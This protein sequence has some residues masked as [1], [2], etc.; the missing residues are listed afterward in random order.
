[1]SS[2]GKDEVTIRNYL[3]GQLSDEDREE[4]E[5]RYF[6]DEELFDELQAAED[7][8]IDDFLSGNLSQ[9]EVDMFQQN[10]LVGRK[11]ERQLRV[12]KAWRNFAAAHAGEKPPKPEKVSNRWQ[13]LLQ[14]APRIG[15][16][17][18]LVA[19]AAVG[20]WQ[21]IPSQ[22]DKALYTLNTAYKQGRPLQSRITKFDY[23]PYGTRGSD[24][25]SVNQNEL[26]EAE[27]KLV[28]IVNRKPTPE[29]HHG[30]GKVFL[31]KKEFDKA[32]EQFELALQEETDNPQIYADLGAALLEKGKLET[33]S[34]RSDSAKSGK[35]VESFARSLTNLNKALEQDQNLLEALYNRALLH[36]AMGLLPQA[37]ED[38]RK[39]LEKDPNSKW[40]NEA[41]ERLSDVEQ[42]RKKTSETSKEIFEKFL[43]E[44][45]SGNEEAAGNIV[46]NYQNRTGN[47]V[48]EKLID[49]YLA[50]SV[51]N[52][53]E[54][55]RQAMNRFASV[56]KLQLHKTG[57]RFFFDLAQFY[58]SSTP[59]QRSLVLQARQIMKQ[60][61]EGWGQINTDE[62]F[63]L[64]D[65]AREL[66]EQARDD[67]EAFVAEYW[68]SFCHYN[69]QLTDL[70]WRVLEP[71]LSASDIRHYLWLQVRALW[72]QSSLET[73]ASEPSK[74]VASSLRAVK[75]ATQINDSVGL[76]NVMCSLMDS[77]RSLSSYAESLTWIQRGL[78]LLSSSRDPIQAVRY[79]TLA[80]STF[81]TIGLHDAAL[82]YEREA[83][84]FA[85]I[86]NSDAVKSQNYA[87]LGAMQGK[88]KNNFNEALKNVQ[89]AFDLAQAHGDSGRMAYAALQMGEVYREAGDF[90]KAVDRYTE[91]INIYE[92]DIEKFKTYLYQ[93]HK[94]RVLCY[95]QQHNDALAQAEFS[96]LFDLIDKYR[97]TISDEGSRDTFFD[98]EQS[99]VDVA[100]DFEYSRMNNGEQ[101]FNHSNSS[102]ARSLLDLLNEANVKAR[103]EEAGNKFQA[104]SEPRSLETIMTQLPAQTQVVQY[105]VLEDKLLFFVISQNKFQVEM[106]PISK[107]DLN[108]KLLRFL[109]IVSRPPQDD[110]SQELLLAKDL[111]SILIK[112]VESLLDK[113]KLLCIIPDG[114]LSYLPFAALVSPE[115]GRYLFEDHPL[116][117]SPS[118]SVFLT[119]SENARQKTGL[120]AERVLSVG[121][122]TFDRTAFRDF[123][124][125][126][127][128]RREAV[129][130]GS[131]YKS[132]V[133]LPENLATRA[134]VK[135]N[136]ETSD[137]AHFALHSQIENEVPL[138][139]KLLLAKTPKMDQVS[140]SVIY[141][142]EIYNLKLS[143]TRLVVL[144]SCESGAGRYYGGEGVNSL[145][146]AF[147][148]AG[149]PLVVGSLWPVQTNA[150]EK[151]MVSFHS[152]RTK[153]QRSSTVEA[154]RRAQQEMAH[155]PAENLHRPYY[156]AAFTVTG[157]YAPF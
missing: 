52:K 115:S 109:N 60:G 9:A 1:M 139:S 36:E 32:I 147:L 63:R 121:N 138:R 106:Q 100:I 78:P 68:M 18:A 3:L 155:G 39:Y 61:Y 5:R 58:Q 111:Y 70:S 132:R 8:L 79:F 45:N 65:N 51:Q 80:A 81:S 34:A 130:V 72:L 44:F 140:D 50:A 108:E 114:T 35:G 4:F 37:E 46:S 31:A 54:D 88:L 89:L 92:K 95:L 150:T 19:V 66:F 151:L 127:E 69:K 56:G 85:F 86:T 41:R 28:E 154:L 83:L 104:V 20:V 6:S 42:Q 14:Y 59:E 103:V 15:A 136:I 33:V 76:L 142:Y 24:S 74:A 133:V 77:Y 93:A 105:V 135:D 122:P 144:S 98:V 153:E 125:L 91:S 71:V 82:D 87:F 25:R 128:A 157:G 143:R 73:K 123:D 96:I 94:G 13:F 101:A 22:V 7:D 43:S 49:D 2:S 21:L 126:P 10:F 12:G 116:M 55:A 152:N 146:R 148:G 97:R 30:L 113:Q 137:V 131:L 16:V 84:R 134:A 118:L 156:W 67:P 124:D 145:A 47:V 107:K 27:L 48:V 75:I 26:S 102:R 17:A 23:A 29:A 99:V 120:K 57:D 90:D 53:S 149:V 112:P 62:N 129:E 119:C 11:R 110:E 38:W 117:T 141:A 40:A 64:F